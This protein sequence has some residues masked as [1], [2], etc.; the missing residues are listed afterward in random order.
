MSVVSRLSHFDNDMRGFSIFGSL[1]NVHIFR[2]TG[3]V[4][5]TFPYLQME[6]QGTLLGDS[7]E[8]FSN[9][10]LFHNQQQVIASRK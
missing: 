9:E 1:Q 5:A 7:E 3:R 6:R 10:P 2:W 4:L 8:R